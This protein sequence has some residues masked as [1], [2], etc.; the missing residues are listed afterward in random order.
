MEDNV[1]L[2]RVHGV[3]PRFTIKGRPF[4]P[5]DERHESLELSLLECDELLCEVVQATILF[6]RSSQLEFDVGMTLKACS[7]PWHERLLHSLPLAI[8]SA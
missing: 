5:L 8:N 6:E 1:P 2:V 4:L 3:T 7:K